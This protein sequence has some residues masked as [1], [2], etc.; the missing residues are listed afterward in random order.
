MDD[1]HRLDDIIIE[2]MMHQL[3]AGRK[4]VCMH[5][6]ANPLLQLENLLAADTGVKAVSFSYWYNLFL[7][8]LG[9]KDQQ[10]GK[11]R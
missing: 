2:K 1:G 10:H 5:A 6:K 3:H 4:A 8:F 9:T 7:Q 11:Q